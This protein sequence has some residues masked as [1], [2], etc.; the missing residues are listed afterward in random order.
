MMQTRWRP[1]VLALLL[2]LGLTVARAADSPK[3]HSAPVQAP[4]CCCDK[5]ESAGSPCSAEAHAV[6]TGCPQSQG[7]PSSCST[8]SCC[9]E[10]KRVTPTHAQ[11]VSRSKIKEGPLDQGLRATCSF[12]FTNTPLRQVVDDL[13]S[14]S[15]LNIVADEPALAEAGISLDRPVTLG[16][17]GVSLKKALDLL[18]HQMQLTYIVQDEVL[19]ITTPSQVTRGQLVT[20]MYAVADLIPPA[21]RVG[22][23][24]HQ[25]QTEGPGDELIH[26][27]TRTIAPHTWS[28]MG[29]SGTIEYYPI[30]QGLA[31]TQTVD[32]QEQVAELLAAL[33][34]VRDQESVATGPKC[35]PVSPGMVR[36]LAEPTPPAPTVLCPSSS[37]VPGIVRESAKPVSATWVISAVVKEGQTQLEVQSGSATRLICKE[38]LL[39]TL[40]GQLKLGTCDKQIQLTSP[41]FQAAA[42]RL[43]RTEMDD[44]VVLEGRVWLQCHEEVQHAEVFAERIVVSL[45]DG[46][47]EIGPSVKTS[48]PD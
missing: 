18:L 17:K 25:V 8:A 46:R 39:E 22:R 34:R 26:L 1:V 21:N 12:H 28:T 16:L 6:P 27:V 10:N 35:L 45:K 48:E 36:V 24:S 37:P 23:T 14:L 5:P 4:K 31:V 47:L 19:Q 30:G 13:R 44:G 32:I 15:G 11:L 9:Q 20:K 2:A 40:G 29:G 7:C 38:M 3:G 42:D 33:Q 41:F 43:A